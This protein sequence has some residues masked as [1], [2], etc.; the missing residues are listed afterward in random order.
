MKRTTVGVLLI[1]V[2]LG[3]GVGFGI[4]LVLTT[5]ARPTFLPDWLLPIAQVVIAAA[6]LLFA[7]PI[8]RSVRNPDAPRVDPFRAL[9]TAVLARASSMLGAVLGGFAGGLLIFVLTRPVQPRVGSIA[10]IIVS[11]VASV[12]LVVAALVAEYF[13]TLPK[14]DDDDPSGLDGPEAPAHH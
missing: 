7:W 5:M 14:D 4:D 2:V 10:V 1:A 13:C 8:R 9:R 6:V 11:L 3:L 12:V